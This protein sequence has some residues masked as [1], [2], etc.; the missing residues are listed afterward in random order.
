MKAVLGENM[1]AKNAF[2]TIKNVSVRSA[3]E[4]DLF[5]LRYSHNP[6]TKKGESLRKEK[7]Y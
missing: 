1:Y 3:K 4:H 5:F 2:S 7:E 6:H